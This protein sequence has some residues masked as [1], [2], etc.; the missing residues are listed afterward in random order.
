M[1]ITF[2][3]PLPNITHVIPKGHTMDAAPGFARKMVERGFAVWAAGEEEV[4]SEQSV[5]PEKKPETV[6]TPDPFEMAMRAAH[7][8]AEETPEKP[9]EISEETPANAEKP[10]RKGRTRAKS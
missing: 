2:I 4:K 9:G 8:M 7:E 5:T 6:Q 3:K 10:A 1:K